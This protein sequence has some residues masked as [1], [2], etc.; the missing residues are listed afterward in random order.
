MGCQIRNADAIHPDWAQRSGGSLM[1]H[2]KAPPLEIVAVEEGRFLLAYMAPTQS[3]SLGGPAPTKRWMKASWAFLLQPRRS[4][5][6][7]LI[8]RYR[9]ATSNDLASRLQFG[10]AFVEPI[11][12]A[13]DRGMLIGIK[14][15]AEGASGIQS[16][17][18]PVSA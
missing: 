10:A 3:L 9:C 18:A 1:L 5:Q 17:R 13:M 7:Q 16:D 11:S 2:P 14:R 12:F 8:S 15:R 6:C 4:D